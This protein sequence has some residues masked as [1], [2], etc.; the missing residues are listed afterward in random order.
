MD[1]LTGRYSFG[2][3]GRFDSDLASLCDLKTAEEYLAKLAVRCD[4]GPKA[5]FVK[6]GAA[7]RF[8]VRGGA[9][10]QELQGPSIPD[11]CK[12]RFG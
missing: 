9:S 11:Y 3:E 7:Q 1:A 8:Y 10:T 12:Q 5:A 4:K 2:P 6:D